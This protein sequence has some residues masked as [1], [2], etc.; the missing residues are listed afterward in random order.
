MS[1]DSSRDGNLLPLFEAVS[2]KNVQLQQAIRSGNDRLVAVL[3]R[4]LDP[5]IC[6]MVAYRATEPN[7]IYLQLQLLT[8]LLREDADD[9]SCVLRHT[10]LMSILV[11]RY[12]GPRGLS[13]PTGEA[14]A[15]ML[16]ARP[17][18]SFGDDDVLNESILNSLPDRVAVVTRD[19]RYLFANPSM[20]EMLHSRPIDLIGRSVFDLGLQPEFFVATRDALD[21]AF[22]GE[23]GEFLSRFSRDSQCAPMLHGRFA[24]LRASQGAIN[25][26]VLTFSESNVSVKDIAA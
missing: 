21:L 1:S 11:E 7:E 4:E 16:D 8:K 6:E 10:A 14:I 25:G 19:Y 9:R 13:R 22:L 5:L 15:S 17:Q 18:P 20:A 3:D 12:F 23:N 26:A 2:V 24:P